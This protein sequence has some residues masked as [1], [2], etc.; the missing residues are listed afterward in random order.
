MKGGKGKCNKR[1]PNDV[2]VNVKSSLLGDAPI[3]KSIMRKTNSS[4][5]SYSV[6]GEKVVKHGT[7][8][9]NVLHSTW[10]CSNIEIDNEKDQFFECI[11]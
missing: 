10:W 9:V 7:G 3:L 11:I 2:T 8:D 1:W 4:S 5:A 6:N